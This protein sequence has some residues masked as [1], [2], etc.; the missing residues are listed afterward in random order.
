MGA[1][2]VIGTVTRN[3]IGRMDAAQLLSVCGSIRGLME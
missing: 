2:Q 1:Q 3:I